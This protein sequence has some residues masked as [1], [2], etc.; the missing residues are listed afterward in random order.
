MGV[1]IGINA[2][3]CSVSAVFV[4]ET[5]AAAARV[6]GFT[7]RLG[8]VLV[9]L[10]EDGAE[11]LGYSS[12]RRMLSEADAV[13]ISIPA[14]ATTVLAEGSGPKTGLLV[15]KG[16]ERNLLSDHNHREDV[17]GA[18]VAIEM[19]ESLDEEI[20]P[21]GRSIRE[22]RAEEVREAV[23]RLL[24]KGAEAIVV[25]LRRSP[26]NPM[27][28]TKIREMIEHE[29]PAHYLGA[30]PVVLS[31]DHGDTL[32]DALRTRVALV[33]AYCMSSIAKLLH[34]A[35]DVLRECGYPR[36]L[37]VVDAVGGA[38]RVSKCIP[39][40]CIDS[41]LA[42]DR[43]A[44][45]EIVS[46]RGLK[47]VVILDMGASETRVGFVTDVGNA[48]VTA[49]PVHVG[50]LLSSPAGFREVGFGSHSVLLAESGQVVLGPKRSK[51]ACFGSGGEEPT[52]TD[53]FAVLGL[54]NPDRF[55]GNLAIAGPDAARTVIDVLAH[56]LGVSPEEAAE[57]AVKRVVQSIAEAIQEVV[58]SRGIDCRDVSLLAVGGATGAICCDAGMAL[59]IRAV[60]SPPAGW[61]GSALGAL[62]AP[63]RHTC[64]ARGGRRLSAP[65][66]AADCDWYNS[67]VHGLEEQTVRGMYGEGLSS[68]DLSFDVELEVGCAE[69]TGM[70]AAPRSLAYPEAG[71]ALYSGSADRATSQD[72]VA[73]L[74]VRSFL[75]RATGRG[76]SRT[77]S[78]GET[79]EL[80]RGAADGSEAGARA[81]AI[82]GRREAI[83][84][85][86]PATVDV[87]CR[88]NLRPGD[89]VVGPAIV[90]SRGDAL[91]V[92]RGTRLAVDELLGCTVDRTHTL[93]ADEAPNAHALA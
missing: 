93:A 16:L 30:V 76:S 74:D 73:G 66:S 38:S 2:G 80:F 54:L 23:R 68:G 6:T 88:E 48:F 9:S 56:R 44:A 1:D 39:I 59:G 12:T 65:P 46:S 21:A 84:G 35:E 27:H 72:A 29:Y 7:G 34:E 69:A 87:F 49:S 58:S 41:D 89:V 15:T 42:A 57:H 81:A 55:A 53:A 60:Y 52:L 10:L 79:I 63:V 67:V 86:T 77:L 64:V 25:G 8:P 92:P 11:Q 20:D 78:G 26:L 22:P 36:V 4:G 33:N 91:A 24:Q 37:R 62:L 47:D 18:A 32:D 13:T 31:V 71:K 19:I 90:E 28:E 50:A 75:L 45:A 5:R 82:V 51:P 14:V 70:I 40:D 61:A 83:L 17:S 85:G 43:Y 3:T